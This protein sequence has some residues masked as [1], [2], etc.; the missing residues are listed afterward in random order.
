MAKKTK[1]SDK[2][3][4]PEFKIE[5]IGLTKKTRDKVAAA[6]KKGIAEGKAS[7]PRHKPGTAVTWAGKKWTVVEWQPQNGIGGSY[8]LRN[9]KGQSAVAGPEEV[10]VAKRRAAR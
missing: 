3:V 10:K 7:T 4:L 1:T 2:V 8:W 9:A 6:I 5:I